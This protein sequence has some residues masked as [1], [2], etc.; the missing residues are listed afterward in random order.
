MLQVRGQGDSIEG[1]TAHGATQLDSLLIGM[2][3]WWC[4]GKR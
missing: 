1:M 4:A 3:L 2:R